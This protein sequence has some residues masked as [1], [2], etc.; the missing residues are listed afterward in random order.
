MFEEKLEDSLL[1]RVPQSIIN[2]TS[3]EGG[4]L[5]VRGV[6]IHYGVAPAEWVGRDEPNL[7]FPQLFFLEA[8]APPCHN[9]A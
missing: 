3:P 7:F 1:T 5:S 6:F 2:T 9:S 8:P 4:W